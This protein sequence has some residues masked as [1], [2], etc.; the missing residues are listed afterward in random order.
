MTPNDKTKFKTTAQTRALA[1]F[2]PGHDAKRIDTDKYVEGYAA[3]YEP[4]ILYYDIDTET[5]ERTPIYER[6]ERG[7]FASA[8]MSD[9]IMQYDHQGKVLARTGNGSLVVEVDDTGLFFA[10][11]LSRTEAARS[12]YDDVTA[13]M[14]TK[15]S[16]RFRCGDYYY[17]RENHT[18]VH[19]RI[20][21]VYDVAAVSI[22][23]ND[24][25]EINARAWVD[26]EIAQAARSEAE[27]EE[28]RR[29]LRA[30]INIITGGF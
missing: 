19:T 6:F 2:S 26:G 21:K 28:R 18:I 4:Y 23:A 12:L 17:D 29:K 14:V 10:A 7:C 16:W 13:G 27:L 1:V 25:T 22:P 9:I 11:D 3:R 20:D 24:N 5:G 15:M 8:D 30:K